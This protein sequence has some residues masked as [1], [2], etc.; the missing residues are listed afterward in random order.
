M[1]R[2]RR[3]WYAEMEWRSGYFAEEQQKEQENLQ[4]SLV[5]GNGDIVV[6]CCMISEVAKLM[7]DARELITM[8]VYGD[9]GNII[10]EEIP[11]ELLSYMEEVLPEKKKDNIE[12]VLDTLINVEEFHRT[13][14]R[15]SYTN[16]YFHD[17]IALTFEC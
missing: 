6:E 1:C 9:N 14:V 12:N 8:D 7:G 10:A 2:I 17:I 3:L 15:F 4:R 5:K 11:P 16:P 13:N